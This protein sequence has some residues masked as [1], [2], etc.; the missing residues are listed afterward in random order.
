VADSIRDLLA[1]YD[2][3]LA[4]VEGAD[5]RLPALGMSLARLRVALGAPAGRV[6]LMLDPAAAPRG[7]RDGRVSTTVRV[8]LESPSGAPDS[9]RTRDVRFVFRRVPDAGWTIEEVRPER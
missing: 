8:R 5:A 4:G 1:R 3:A 2:D 9:S 7:L 6:Q